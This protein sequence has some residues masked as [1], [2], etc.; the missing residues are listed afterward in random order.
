MSKSKA[1]N[2]KL[3]G[4]SF[5]APAAQ[6][7][8][9]FN[10]S[11]GFDYRLYKHDIQGSLAHAQMLAE[12]GIISKDDYQEI[13]RGLNII[14]EEI[15]SDTQAWI[16]AR[17]KDEDIHMAIERRLTELIGD[18]GRKLHSAR[19][20]NDQVAVDLRLWLRDELKIT[21]TLV[22]NLR[23][24]LIKKANDDLNCILP[25]YTHLQHAQPISLGHYWL[26]HEAKLSR[27][28]SRLSDALKRMNVN[29][30]GSG[31]LSGTS[32]P[33][34]RESTTLALG[35]DRPSENSLDAVSDRDYVAEY[36]FIISMIMVHLS[37]LAEEMI[38]WSTKEF[39]FIEISDAFATGSSMMPQKKNPDVPE[40]I[41]GK[42]GRVIGALQALLV[43]LK[44]LPLAYN[45]DLQE[46]KEML[47]QANDT[48][49]VC[50]RITKEFLE[51]ISANKDRM[52][53]A[54]YNSYADATDAAE[55]L[56][57]KGIPFRVAY[58]AVGKAVKYAIERKRLLKE[59]SISEW[60]SMHQSFSEDMED[61]LKPEILVDSRKITGGTARSEVLKAI[62]YAQ[63]RLNQENAN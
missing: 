12:V 40:L 61:L 49:Q 34:D 52:Y 3:W 57:R 32:C 41:R 8:E 29:P 38:L 22:N 25:G 4:A 35:F 43:T 27:D 1:E 44:G 51:N 16:K 24:T 20:R 62:N 42:T 46:D 14:L 9:E 6:I 10:N 21:R 19:S 13:K 50:L 15:S 17:S 11:I 58:E 63:E 36:E 37:Q 30:L 39:G 54:I 23:A 60:Q 26:A 47:F 31:A 5:S 7:L 2:N 28:T 55:Y 59:L 18:A 53:D 33:I 48:V 56:V 45:K